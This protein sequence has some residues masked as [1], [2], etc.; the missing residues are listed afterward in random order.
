MEIPSAFLPYRFYGFKEEVLERKLL[1]DLSSYKVLKTDKVMAA[2]TPLS[3]D[4]KHF[5]RKMLELK[6]FITEVGASYEERSAIIEKLHDSWQEY[7]HVAA[8]IN[9]FDIMSAQ[10]FE[11]A[12]F[13]LMDTNVRYGIDLRRSSIQKFEGSSLKTDGLMYEIMPCPCDS[14]ELIEIAKTSWSDYKVAIDRF[15]A[16]KSIPER[17]ADSVYTE[18]LKNSLAGE[19]ADI[20]VV[21]RVD[22]KA[23]GFLALKQH[24]DNVEESKIGQIVLGAVDPSMRGKN[25]YTCMVSLALRIL[26]TKTDIVE[27]GTQVTNYAPQKVWAQ[28]GLKLV[29]TTYTFH[30]ELNSAQRKRTQSNAD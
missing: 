6:Y 7:D 16:D 19:L 22:G 25:V 13:S 17:L 27:T 21:P 4:S 18:W 9:A 1:S 28:H 5:H 12:G 8:R 14:G 15:Y 23:V 11:R 10:V 24:A 26:R 2:W 29:S 3:W 20:V 30:K